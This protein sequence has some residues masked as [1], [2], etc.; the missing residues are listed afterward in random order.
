VLELAVTGLSNKEIATRLG[1]SPRTVEVH[2]AW[3]MERMGA[4]SLAELVRMEMKLRP[5]RT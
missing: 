5:A 2:R 3:M 1:I 4:R